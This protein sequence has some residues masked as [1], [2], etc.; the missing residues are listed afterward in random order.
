[1]VRAI[2]EQTASTAASALGF[3]E[4]LTLLVQREIAW[5]D[6]KRVA[7]LM[8]AARLKVSTAC[9]ED[10]NWRARC[11]VLNGQDIRNF[12][13]WFPPDLR[14]VGVPAAIPAS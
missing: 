14:I 6:D 7:R 12:K 9:V 5:R 3:D 11:A 13:R 10:I 4:R 1:M 8:K 2:E